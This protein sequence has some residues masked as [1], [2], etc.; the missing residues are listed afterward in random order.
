MQNATVYF[1]FSGSEYYTRVV[2]VYLVIE[3]EENVLI[4][5]IFYGYNDRNATTA[6]VGSAERPEKEKSKKDKEE[7]ADKA[8]RK[9]AKAAK[10]SIS[11]QV[12]FF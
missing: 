6:A 2:I 1:T 9:A 12:F 7:K 10:V 11:S 4:L 5:S 3:Y 8:E